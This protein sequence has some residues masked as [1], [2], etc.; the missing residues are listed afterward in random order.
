V[1]VNRETIVTKFMKC[2][3]YAVVGLGALLAAGH[4]VAQTSPATE[5]QKIAQRRCAECHVIVAHGPGSWTDAP[6]FESIANRPDI[7][8]NWLIT[9]IPKPHVHM[10]MEKYTHAQV[11]SLADYILSLRQK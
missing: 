3:A 1:L 6:S 9:F 5:G 4:A 7:T 11:E 2:A 8:R 10:E